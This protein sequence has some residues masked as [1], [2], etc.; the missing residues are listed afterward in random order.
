MS[1]NV[2]DDLLLFSGSCFRDGIAQITEFLLRIKEK[3]Q[4]LRRPVKTPLCRCV[5]PFT[6]PVKYDINAGLLRCF[7]PPVQ[8]RSIVIKPL[9]LF[10]SSIKYQCLQVS[11]LPCLS[12]VSRQARSTYQSFFLPPANGCF[13]W[14]HAAPRRKHKGAVYKTKMAKEKLKEAESLNKNVEFGV[15]Y[16][17]FFVLLSSFFLKN[18][19]IVA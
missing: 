1:F 6:H 3:S 9:G 4:K 14:Q 7:W 11:S 19:I 15:K 12:A 18:W 17:C 10:C 16:D 8:C 13:L 2:R 5:T